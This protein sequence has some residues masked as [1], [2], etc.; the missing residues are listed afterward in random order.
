[1]KTTDARLAD[2]ERRILAGFVGKTLE[3]Y[4]CSELGTTRHVAWGVVELS[5]EGHA[6]SLVHKE[7]QV[8][9][10]GEF[11]DIATTSVREVEAEEFACELS[12]VRMVDHV[13]GQKI[14]DIRIYED[15]KFK[16]K[17]GVDIFRF[18]TTVA[19]VLQLERSQVVFSGSPI[20]EAID[21]YRGPGA[22][23]KIRPVEADECELGFCFRTERAVIDLKGWLGGQS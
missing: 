1:M 19:I 5:V 11:E 13:V 6:C 4:R 3:K 2:G 23:K 21:I 12:N 10:F 18:A 22:E 7:T 8:D 20:T 15:S 16:S 17:D 14:Q 9:Y